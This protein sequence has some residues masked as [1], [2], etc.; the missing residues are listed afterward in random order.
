MK[1]GA[2][3]PVYNRAH[4]IG[5]A[6]ESILAQTEPVKEIL[7][8]DD[9]STDDLEGALRPFANAVSLIRHTTNQGASAARNTG[10]AAATGEYIAFLDSDDVWKP[11]KLQQQM[12]FMDRL[13]LDISCTNFEL[14]KSDWPGP[15]VA[16]RPYAEKIGRNEFLWGCYTCPGSTLI[17]K[18]SI[19]LEHGGYDP[20]FPRYEDWDLLLRLTMNGDYEVGFLN[21]PL[22]SVHL[23][24][25]PEPAAAAAG[26]DRMLEQHL[27]PLSTMNPS[28]AR[29]LLSAVEFGRASLHAREGRYVKTGSKLLSSLFL[30]PL[31]NQAVRMILLPELRDAVRSQ[32]DHFAWKASRSA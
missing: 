9:G 7:I 1:I 18:R 32:G 16:K 2:I 27:E 14:I 28:L 24:P 3:I 5:R 4:C 8:V 23:G 6:V 11:G 30:W 31:G 15:K 17:I 26:L 29:R 25:R 22:A 20:S 12:A 10:M 21:A 13:S 19:L